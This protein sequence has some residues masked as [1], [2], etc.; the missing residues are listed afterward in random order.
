M[1]LTLSKFKMAGRAAVLA[2]VL[3]AS[4]LSA[5]PAQAAP[6][7]PSFNFNLQLPNGGGNLQF[8]N[9]NDNGRRDPGFRPGPNRGRDFC[10]NDREVRSQL[11][12]NGFDN[13]RVG[14]DLRRGWVEVFATNRRGAYTMQVNRCT[15]QVA[16]VQRIR[17]GGG[18]APVRPGAG[19]GLQ[20][21]Y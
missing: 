7:D 13:V 6:G 2:I 8:G 19:F 17:R 5:M 12:D 15:G 3:G 4:A 16:N 9:G 14:R 21:G 20:F 18:D 10:L 1:T 11:G